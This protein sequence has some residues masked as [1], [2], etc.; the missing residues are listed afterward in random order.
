M[1][2]DI[3]TIINLQKLYLNKGQK[4]EIKLKGKRR[5]IICT[6]LNLQYKSIADAAR[7]LNLSHAQISSCLCG[8]SKTAGGHSFS[9]L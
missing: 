2:D 3:A 6:D 9:Y 5:A 7:Q 8:K 4:A 1:A